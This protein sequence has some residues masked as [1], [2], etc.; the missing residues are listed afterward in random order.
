MDSQQFS[1]GNIGDMPRPSKAVG[2][3]VSCDDDGMELY[4]MRSNSGVSFVDWEGEANGE[5]DMSLCAPKPLR[6]VSPDSLSQ[7]GEDHDD[8]CLPDIDGEDDFHAVMFS[9]EEWEEECPNVE[10]YGDGDFSC[11]QFPRPPDRDGANNPLHEDDRLMPFTTDEYSQVLGVSPPTK[12]G[13]MRPFNNEN[14]LQANFTHLS[15]SC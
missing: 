5:E 11:F 2:I 15:V 14:A 12:L 8:A 9:S 1:G 3:I 10:V 6:T 13:V 7:D 4:N